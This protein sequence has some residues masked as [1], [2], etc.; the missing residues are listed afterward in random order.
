MIHLTPR[1]TIVYVTG[2]EKEI[3]DW[4]YAN[5]RDVMVRKIPNVEFSI[6]H[7]AWWN[8]YFRPPYDSPVQPHAYGAT[9][10]LHAAVKM[11]NPGD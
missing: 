7:A 2:R 8:E 1:Y 4:T 6:L 11:L 3:S 5:A 9:L 10:A